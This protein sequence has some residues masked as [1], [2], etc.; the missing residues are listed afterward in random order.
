SSVQVSLTTVPDTG[1]PFD[2]G[3]VARPSETDV[4]CNRWRCEDKRPRAAVIGPPPR[5]D[6]HIAFAP[7]QCTD[8][9]DVP[10]PDRRMLAGLRRAGRARLR[11]LRA[12]GGGRGCRSQERAA[13][14]ALRQP[15][16]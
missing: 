10:L 5:P 9:F 3:G 2:A 7:A 6:R 15:Q 14:A 16:A 13:D 4:L 12:C 11:L 8:E 1:V